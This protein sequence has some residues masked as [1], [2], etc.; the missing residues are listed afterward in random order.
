MA[1]DWNEHACAG[2]PY[3]TLGVGLGSAT[4]GGWIRRDKRPPLRRPFEVK[5]FVLSR[6]PSHRGP[7]P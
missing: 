7:R 2:E 3:F 6:Y 1:L 5:S 4:V